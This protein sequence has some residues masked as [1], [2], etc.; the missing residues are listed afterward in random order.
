MIN[1]SWVKI[2]PTLEKV[3]KAIRDNAQNKES[4]Q[5]LAHDR[6]HGTTV[7]RVTIKGMG[8]ANGNYLFTIYHE[9]FG[10]TKQEAQELRE[11]FQN[12]QLTEKSDDEEKV[13]FAEMQKL[14]DE[15]FPPATT[16]S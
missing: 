7:D 11:H 12:Y 6:E 16:E 15:Y 2:K 3:L 4:Y 13:H 10:I 5:A 8:N 14:I 1:Q 9:D